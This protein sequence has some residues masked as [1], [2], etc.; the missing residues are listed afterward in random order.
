MR[1]EIAEAQCP[2]QRVRLFE[3]ATAL[4][5]HDHD[6]LSLHGDLTR[7]GEIRQRSIVIA[8]HG[9]DPR[10]TPERGE[11]VPRIDV[12]GVEDQVDPCDDIAESI[13][14]PVEKFGTVRIRHDAHPRGHAARVAFD[15]RGIVRRTING[16]RL[17]IAAIPNTTRWPAPKAT[18]PTSGPT[19]P[20]K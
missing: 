14:K 9:L 13:R 18:A 11:R 12:P 1:P 8:P 17:R 5:V 4:A 3:P 19:T 7:G 20:P 10:Q 2:Q 6:P 16:A 15:S